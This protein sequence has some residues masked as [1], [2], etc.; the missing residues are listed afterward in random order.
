MEDR[1]DLLIDEE[2]WQA[3]GDPTTADFIA[4]G[5]FVLKQAIDSGADGAKE[6]SEAIQADI[7][8]AY[9]HT[10]AHGAALRLYLLSLTGR[11]KPQDEPLQLINGA[12]QR[13]AAEIESARKGREAKKQRG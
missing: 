8:A 7:E 1:H 6:A 13:G 9:L 4:R 12:I 3:I 2:A 10:D 5:L 11:L